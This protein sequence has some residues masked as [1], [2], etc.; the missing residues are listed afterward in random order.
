MILVRKLVVSLQLSLYSESKQQ[1]E[2]STSFL[3]YDKAMY[4]STS[5]LMHPVRTLTINNFNVSTGNDALIYLRI[6]YK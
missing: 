3:A 5:R 4:R 6:L 2:R 1:S